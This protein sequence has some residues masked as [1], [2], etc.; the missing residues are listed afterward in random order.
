MK[1]KKKY[2]GLSKEAGR[3]SELPL[4]GSFVHLSPCHAQAPFLTKVSTACK[5]EMW[6][7]GRFGS[8]F[9]LECRHGETAQAAT[10]ATTG[11]EAG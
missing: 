11:L 5:S 3:T 9:G 4:E 8:S 7:V 2:S 10:K 1:I 6:E